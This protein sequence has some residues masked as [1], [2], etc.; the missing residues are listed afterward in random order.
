[1]KMHLLT[2]N[3]ITIKTSLNLQNDMFLI[4]YI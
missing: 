3:K 1:M 2:M 4:F